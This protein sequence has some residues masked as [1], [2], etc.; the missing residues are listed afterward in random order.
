M[1]EN[2]NSV[3]RCEPGWM[4]AARRIADLAATISSCATNEHGEVR[5][6]LIRGWANEIIAQC[7]V[8]DMVTEYNRETFTIANEQH[9]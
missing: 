1:S 5:R 2:A 4:C 8:W 6:L 9:E 3:T 7:D